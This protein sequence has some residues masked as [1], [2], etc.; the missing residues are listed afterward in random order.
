[1]VNRLV[2][3][4]IS[5]SVSQRIESG[6]EG[7][8]VLAVFERA[9]NLVTPR[10]DVVALVL[11]EIGNGPLNVVVEEAGRSEVPA[12]SGLFQTLEPGIAGRIEHSC[13]EAGELEV[14]LERAETWEPCPDWDQLRR[15]RD[16]IEGRLRWVQTLALG[17]PP[18]GSFLQLLPN[19]DPGGQGLA[20]FGKPGGLRRQQ[21]TEGGELTPDLTGLGKP[22]RSGALRHLEAGWA[23]DA[24]ALRTGAGLVAG[25]GGGLTPAGDDFLIGVML[26]A[27]LAHPEAERFCRCLLEASAARTMML[28]A[29]FLRSAAEGE[30]SAA[31]HCL[32]GA[33]DGGTK[34]ELA[35]AVKNVLSCGHTSGAD[36]LAG[37]VW[38]GLASSQAA[39]GQG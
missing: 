10:G 32:L 34:Q 26:W 25:L 7:A 17:Q 23:G 33:L 4:S 29:A 28:A 8:R 6:L 39:T 3:R 18:A 22:V 13:L 37:F 9:C 1:V 31:W 21:S 12:R 19:Q 20:G 2:A 15:K 16:A 38:M 14:E 30:C 35:G 24:D 5:R 11:P 27:W 36:T